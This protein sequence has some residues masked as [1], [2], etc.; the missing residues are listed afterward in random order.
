M[1]PNFIKEELIQNKNKKVEVTAYGMR[2]KTNKYYGTIYGIYPNIF[3][4]K[5]REIEKSFSYS[6]VITGEVKIK[7]K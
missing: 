3:T 4:I 5:D 2:G 1:N 6:D 7:Y